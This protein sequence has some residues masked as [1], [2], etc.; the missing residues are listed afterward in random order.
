MILCRQ[1]LYWSIIFFAVFGVSFSLQKAR[2][3]FTAGASV[4]LSGSPVIDLS[5]VVRTGAVHLEVEGGE[6]EEVLPPPVVLGDEGEEEIVVVEVDVDVDVAL[7]PWDEFLKIFSVEALVESPVPDNFMTTEDVIFKPGEI[8]DTVHILD[9]EGKIIEPFLFPADKDIKREGLRPY[10]ISLRTAVIAKNPQ[11]LLAHARFKALL[12]DLGRESLLQDLES[13]PL[14]PDALVEH[15][16]AWVESLKERFVIPY[17]EDNVDFIRDHGESPTEWF[18]TTFRGWFQLAK[19][20]KLTAP[21]ATTLLDS[22]RDLGTFLSKFT[23]DLFALFSDGAMEEWEEEFVEFVVENL[24]EEESKPD[25]DLTPD[26]RRA[27]LRLKMLTI[28]HMIMEAYFTVEAMMKSMKITGLEEGSEEEFEYQRLRFEALEPFVLDPSTTDL[29]RE[30]AF[31]KT[32]HFNPIFMKAQK[33]VSAFSEIYVDFISNALD[34]FS[35][36]GLLLVRHPYL[37][38]NTQSLLELKLPILRTLVPCVE[39]TTPWFGVTGPATLKGMQ[40]ALASEC[41]EGTDLKKWRK[42]R[43][44]LMSQLKKKTEGYLERFQYWNPWNKGLPAVLEKREES[45]AAFD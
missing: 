29:T 30:E 19:G 18:E 4:S 5:A 23:A 42:A 11:A 21:Q 8:K 32:L 16:P 27:P 28:H 7:D 39:T 44:V 9:D 25:L 17:A 1:T 6:D 22:V 3:V 41:P 37:R 43:E 2:A 20:E 12:K 33:D 14:S 26:E 15:F 24:E 35:A 40:T 45:L 38:E 13:A 31:D 34:A 10:F 36:Q